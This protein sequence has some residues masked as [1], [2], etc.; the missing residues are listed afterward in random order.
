M[1][2]EGKSLNCLYNGP[3][4]TMNDTKG[5]ELLSN[6]CPK[7]AAD[8]KTC[9]SAKQ[10]KT[11][12][13]NLDT[14]SQFASRCPACLRNL[15]DLFCELTCSPDQSLFMDPVMLLPPF[16]IPGQKQSILRINYY[17]SPEFKKGLFDSCKDVVFPENN[18]KI[19]NLICGESAETCTPEKLVTYMGSTSNGMSPFDIIFPEEIPQNLRWMNAETFKCNESFVNPWTKQT[20]LKCSCKDCKPS[21]KV[22]TGNT[23]NNPTK[24]SPQFYRLEKL[25]ITVNPDYP[26]KHTGYHQYPDSKFIPFGN[27]FH[28]DLLN[29][30]R[31]D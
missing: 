23:A 28:L 24:F 13:D 6:I 4:R 11:L 29:Q 17:A 31:G 12:D 18:E 27:I 14:L 1:E 9:C 16:P 30:V 8:R 25:I 22:P 21:C 2:Q 26:Q 3:T 19:F 20:Q 10:L 15:I 5:L 7:Y